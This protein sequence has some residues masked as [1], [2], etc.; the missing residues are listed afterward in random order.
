MDEKLLKQIEQYLKDSGLNAIEL[1]KRMDEVKASTAEFNRELINAQRHF[2]EMNSD[3]TD[4]A[5]QLKNVLRDL[6]RTNVTSKDINSSFNLLNSSRST[7]FIAPEFIATNC[8]LGI[9]VLFLSS[10]I[11]V[12]ANTVKLPLSTSVFPASYIGNKLKV[13]V[14]GIFSQYVD[15]NILILFRVIS[16][17]SDYSLQT[18]INYSQMNFKGLEDQLLVL[19][20]NQS[21]S[22]AF[23]EIYSRYWFKIYRISFNQTGNKEEAEELVQD[24]FLSIWNRRETIVINNLDL[25]LV[26]SIKNKVYDLIR[27][28]INFRKYQEH[29]ILKEIDFHFNTDEIVNYTE[30]TDAVEKVLSLLPEKSVHIFKKSRFENMN[31]KEIAVQMKLSEKA[32]E[33]H[34]TKSLKF[35]KENLK[36]YS[37][38]N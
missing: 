8:S 17:L 33:Y 13:S 4:L 7:L 18:K 24:V 20:L 26:I 28:K 16:M 22:A 15:K 31:T 14:L 3:F 25:Y 38:L 27:S 1:K 21:H 29:I 35:L 9:I 19:G 11:G 30:L 10:D 2:S 36:D 37:R 23:E 12:V 34:I 5:D 32:V 6:S